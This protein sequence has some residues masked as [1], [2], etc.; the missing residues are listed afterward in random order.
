MYHYFITSG[1]V[2]IPTDDFSK[3][4]KTSVVNGVNS[5][6][7]HL[8]YPNGIVMD[9]TLTIEGADITI[10]RE[11]VQNADGDYVLKEEI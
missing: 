4:K 11:L 3:V 1:N 6:T 8:E 5:A 7:M 10:N 9:T 2:K